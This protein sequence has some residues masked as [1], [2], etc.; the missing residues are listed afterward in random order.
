[1]TK[2][3]Y[4]PE[5]LQQ[6]VY[7]TTFMLLPPGGYSIW[8]TEIWSTL[9]GKSHIRNNRDDTDEPLKNNDIMCMLVALVLICNNFDFNVEHFHQ[10]QGAAMSTR[11]ATTIAI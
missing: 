9:S 11:V 10:A 3:Y 8:G 6:E 4:Y 5:K 2:Q 1:M 7:M